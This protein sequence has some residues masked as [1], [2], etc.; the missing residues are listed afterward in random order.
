M[1]YKTG[2]QVVHAVY[3]VGEVAAVEAMKFDGR[4]EGLFYRLAFNGST[5]VWV[6]V[7]DLQDERLRPVTPKR[8][9]ARYRAVLKAPP[10]ALDQDFQYRRQA[11]ETRLKKHTFLQLCELVRDLHGLSG[12]KELNQHDVNL[13]KNARAALVQEWASASGLSPERAMQEIEAMLEYGQ[14]LSAELVAED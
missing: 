8:E 1:T 9:L 14:K 12:V 7:Q 10:V 13:Y 4:Q 5:T 6:Q 11:L 2:D 3:G